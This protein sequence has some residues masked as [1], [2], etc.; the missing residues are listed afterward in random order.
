MSRLQPSKIQPQIFHLVDRHLQHWEFGLTLARIH[1][2][3]FVS[4]DILRNVL[5]YLGSPQARDKGVT[6]GG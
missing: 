5:P 2:A 4:H 6:C 1:V 3:L